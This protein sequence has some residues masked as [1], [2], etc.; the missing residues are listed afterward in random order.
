MRRI[1][2]CLAWATMRAP[3]L[4]RSAIAP[5]SCLGQAIKYLPMK[6]VLE[7]TAL[8]DENLNVVP[9]LKY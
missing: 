6:S 8:S 1:V 2:Q 9:F 3:A 7:M 5:F 4:R